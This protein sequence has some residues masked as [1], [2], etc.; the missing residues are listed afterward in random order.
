MRIDTLKAGEKGLYKRIETVQRILANAEKSCREL[1]LTNEG[2]T[3]TAD[4]ASAAAVLAK[5]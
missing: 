5:A 2:L 3:K 4:R 1:M